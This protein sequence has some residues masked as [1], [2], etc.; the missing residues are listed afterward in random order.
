M[1]GIEDLSRDVRCLTTV[2]GRLV[3]KVETQNLLTRE[4]LNHLN[5]I[6]LRHTKEL[7][8]GIRDLNS[9]KKVNKFIDEKILDIERLMK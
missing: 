1:F 9:K 3:E 7:L 4:H 5:N 2:I 6:G 8:Q